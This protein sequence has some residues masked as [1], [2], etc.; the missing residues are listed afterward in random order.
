MPRTMPLEELGLLQ[1][2]EKIS[3]NA[4]NAIDRFARYGLLQS[5]FI[6]DGEPPVLTQLG[7]ARLAELRLARDEWSV[8]RDTSTA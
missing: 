1:L 8:D 3:D 7:S 5:G 2:L 6:T 4:G